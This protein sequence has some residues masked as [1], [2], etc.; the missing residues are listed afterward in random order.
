MKKYAILKTTFI[1]RAP[2]QWYSCCFKIE[3]IECMVL[4]KIYFDIKRTDL[5]C[6]K[7]A[8]LSRLEQHHL[9]IELIF[10]FRFVLIHLN[11]SFIHAMRIT[12]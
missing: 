12:F 2:F 9:I 8:G 1:R 10:V 4:F 3:R 7:I 11:V 6:N 5:T